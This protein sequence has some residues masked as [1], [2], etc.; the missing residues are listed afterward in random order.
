MLCEKGVSQVFC[1]IHRK[2]SLPESLFNKV[3]G[4]RL[5]TLLEKTL[6]HRSFPTNFT[7]YLRTFYLK[8]P[9]VD[10]FFN[11]FS[12]ELSFVISKVFVADF[13]HVFNC[14]GK[15]RIAIAVLRII[16]KP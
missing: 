4:V 10:S 7:K 11:M 8:N 2:T 13:E 1:K 14:W 12:F 15:N 3:A 6:W 9:P 5:A 16:K